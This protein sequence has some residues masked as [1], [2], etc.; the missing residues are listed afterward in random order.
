MTA[1]SSYQRVDGVGEASIFRGD[2]RQTTSDIDSW[3]VS[4]LTRVEEAKARPNLYGADA[5]FCA[6]R[7][8]LMAHN[9]SLPSTVTSANNA[10]MSIGV[11]LEDMLSEGIRRSGRLI[12]QNRYLIDMPEVRIRGKIDLLFIDPKGQ[13]ALIEVKTCGELPTAPK[14]THLAQ[15]Q[16]YAAV[17]GIRVAYLTYISRNVQGKGAAWSPHLLMRT[18]IV[19]TS[20]NALANRLRIALLSRDAIRKEVSPP[21][22][23]TFRKNTV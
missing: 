4:V 19:D 15:V 14:P 9:Y 21:V 16:T 23:S 2:P 5:G 3:F 11:A 7:N 22:P 20:D 17:S 6:R 10:Y 13:V 12:E 1:K 18:F 8:V